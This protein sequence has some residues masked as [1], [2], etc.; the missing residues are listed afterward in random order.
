MLFAK[1]FA[2]AILCKNE[3]KPCGICDSCISFENNNNPD[4][5]II[6]EDDKSIKTET[7]KQMVKDVYQKP[8]KCSKKIYIINN[9][10]NMTKE[11]QNSILKTLEEPP[12]F[13]VIILISN[14]DNLLLSTIKSRCIRI[15][16]NNLTKNELKEILETKYKIINVT[17][18]ILD[19]SQGSIKKALLFVE[20]ADILEEIKKVF[21]NIESFS[22]I[23]LLN[24]KDSI[25]K[26]KEY[27]FEVLDYINVIIFNKSKENIKYLNGIEFV[28]ET[29][30]RLKKNSNYDMTIDNLLIKLWEEING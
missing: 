5:I 17:D 15:N 24:K 10:E 27:V 29:K 12:E 20:Q 4:F 25:F 18:S 6:D 23:D 28:E 11:A 1:E 8:I 13:I 9:S 30:A 22:I 16:F 7:I 14:N 19:F 3:S 21:T 26:N 2:K